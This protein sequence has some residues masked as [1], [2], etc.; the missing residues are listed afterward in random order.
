MGHQTLMIS[1]C[2]LTLWQ[3][4]L[5]GPGEYLLSTVAKFLL[6]VKQEMNWLSWNHIFQFLQNEKKLP[7]KIDTL[8][9]VSINLPEPSDNLI[10]LIPLSQINFPQVSLKT[11]QACIY[12]YTCI[13]EVRHQ[14]QYNIHNIYIYTLNKNR[15]MYK[16]ITW[17]RCYTR[18]CAM[19]KFPWFCCHS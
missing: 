3:K 13:S 2:N 10:Y 11:L 16:V 6:K 17:S 9:I 12:N 1:A 19:I 7:L 5:N 15:W 4:K 14:N 8:A 18:N